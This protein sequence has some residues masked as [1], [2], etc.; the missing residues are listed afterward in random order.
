MLPSML[1]LAPN[2]LLFRCRHQA[3]CGHVE[4]CFPDPF[5]EA[6]EACSKPCQSRPSAPIHVAL[7]GS[8]DNFL[9]RRYTCPIA[10]TIWRC[11]LG[12]LQ[13]VSRKARAPDVMIFKPAVHPRQTSAKASISAKSDAW[14]ELIRKVPASTLNIC[15]DVHFGHL[16]ASLESAEDVAVPWI[17]RQCHSV[18]SASDVA[19]LPSLTR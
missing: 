15:D 18:A 3:P 1:E 10:R 11:A 8:P 2:T 6:A 4:P 12:I 17:R 16:R 7:A 14:V 5:T 19:A 9:C 13:P